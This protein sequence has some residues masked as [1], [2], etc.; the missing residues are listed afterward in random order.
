MGWL[1]FYA[2]RHPDVP[3]AR[4]YAGMSFGLSLLALIEILSMLGPDPVQALFWF[5]LRVIFTAFTPVLW[6][7]FTLEYAGYKNWLSKRLILIAL[8]IPSLTQIIIWTNHLHGLWVKQ[9]V[10]FHQNGLFWLAETGTRVPGLWF[11]VHS[12]Y[13]LFLTLAG[14][15]VILSTL[16]GKQRLYTGQA[17][18]LV[19]GMLVSLVTTLIPTFNLIPQLEFN[20]FTLGIGMSALFYTLAIFRFHFLKRVPIARPIAMDGPEQRS[21]ALFGLIFLAMAASIAA[22]GYLSY[23]NYQGQFR[24][25]VENQ[26]TSI[27]AMKVDGLQNWRGERLTDVRIFHKNPAFG[28]LVQHYLENPTDPQVQSE[29]NS[30]LEFFTAQTQYDRVFLLNTNGIEQISFPA[31]PAPLSGHLIQDIPAALNSGEETFLDFHRDSDGDSIHLALLVPVLVGGDP[32]PIAI[33][34]L[35]IDPNVYLYP[36]IHQ[37]P[38]P[39]AS[40]ETL[41]IRRE[42]TDAVFLNDP[43]FQPGAAL[44][45]RVPLENTQSPAVRAALGYQGMVE[46][47]DYRGQSVVAAVRSVPDSPWFLEVRMDTAEI[48]APLQERLWQTVFIFGILILVTGMGLGL[49]WRQQRERFFEARYHALE[50]LRE[51]EEKFRKAFQITP[52]AIAIMQL[53]SGH[54]VSVNRGFTNI[55]GYSE[56]EAVG[57]SSQEL[58]LWANLEQRDKM[59]ASLRVNGIVENLEVAFRT[60]AGQI[61]EGLMSAAIIELNGEPHVINSARDITGRKQVERTLR[62]KNEYLTALQATTLELLSQLDP[63]ILLENIVRRAGMLLD[64]SSGYLDLI[65]PETGQ[66]KPRIGMGAL[67]ESLNHQVQP[68]EGVAG[69]VWQTGQ[70]LVVNDYDHWSGR[71]GNYTRGVLASLTGVPLI[72]REQ[73]LGVLGLGYEFSTQRTFEPESVEILTQFA[74]LA[75][76]A[77]ENARLL[78]TTRREL[79]ERKQAEAQI[80]ANQAKLEQLFKEAERSRHTLLSVVEDQKLAEEE[81]RRLNIELERRVAGR[82]AQLEASNKELEAFAYSVSH[83][84]RAPLR[85][86]DGFSRILEQEYAQNLDA[87]GL[88]LIRVIRNNTSKMDRLIIDLLALSRVSR[89]EINFSP[90]D[91]TALV[92]SV[93]YEIATPDALEK[94]MFEV[95]TLPRASGDPTLMRQVWTNLLSNAIKYT[96]PKENCRIEVDG[97]VKEGMCTYSIRDSG[98]GF[99]PKYA[100]KLFGLFQRLHRAGEFEGTGVGL[101]IVQRIIHRHGGQI[102]GESQVDA[103]AT[104]YFTI[105]ESHESDAYED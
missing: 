50:A 63:D 40:A 6:L 15:V 91:M 23:K 57:K 93:Y 102:W 13:A 19:S 30:W 97:W 101:A 84:L 27:A 73:V 17:L 31:L 65:D 58:N 80:L 10:N 22:I 29:L 20:P 1:A 61:C 9:E 11:L 72:Y 92:K 46:G 96:L 99:D 35:R 54:F 5:N 86:I 28:K 45:L 75:A 76:I 37:W 12:F 55:L 77:I 39:S 104:F 85:A 33:L 24:T 51:S 25:Q 79:T 18:L 90:V 59:I 103:G 3:G 78:S 81:I 74:R 26:L 47:V 49:V 89:S 52:D 105:P 7:L 56:A 98:V 67:A 88:R 71:V 95:S 16:W 34:L 32:R 42:G 87:E 83:D 2:W 41:L 64:T 8:I 53:S 43:R 100:H 14:I 44:N 70:P 36:L 66:L 82:T 48:Y 62:W 69:I 21:L 38:V 68:G 4:A 60:K 94:F